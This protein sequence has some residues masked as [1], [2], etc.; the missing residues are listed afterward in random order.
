MNV[1]VESGKGSVAVS[2]SEVFEMTV[3]DVSPGLWFS[4]TG[5]AGSEAGLKIMTANTKAIDGFSGA[6]KLNP[7]Y[8]SAMTEVHGRYI[9][10]S[11]EASFSLVIVAI[12][13]FSAKG[14]RSRMRF[15]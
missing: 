1:L 13:I 9:T 7:Y 2:N 8:S 5:T 12:Q 3:S 15:P 6:L 4:G 11:I 10:V 14:L